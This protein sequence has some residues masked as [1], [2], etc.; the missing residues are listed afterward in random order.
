MTKR[1]PEEREPSS[2]AKRFEKV[3]RTLGCDED[4]AAFKD[5]LRKLLS[6]PVPS[7]DDE[8]AKGKA[9]MKRTKG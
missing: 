7:K 8:K 2:Q 6:A 5:R 1:M 4:E 3:A 9:A